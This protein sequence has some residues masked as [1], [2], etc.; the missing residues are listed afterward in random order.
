MT[1]QRF[2]HTLPMD[3]NDCLA[4]MLSTS[5]FWKEGSIKL[6]LYFIVIKVVQKTST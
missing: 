4:S 1:Y 3:S 2:N 6:Q 5:E